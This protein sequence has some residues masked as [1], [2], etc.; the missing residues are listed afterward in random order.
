M[1]TAEGE[2]AVVGGIYRERCMR[3]HWN[4]VFGSAGRA[5]SALSTFGGNVCLHGFADGRTEEAIQAHAALEGFRLQLTTVEAVA[6]FHYIHGLARPGIKLPATALPTLRV[7]AHNVLQFGTLEPQ[8]IVE[9]D[10]AV[11]DPQNVDRPIGFRANGST[12]RELALVLNQGEART[13]VGD[14][15]L[16]AEALASKLAEQE[17]ADVVVIKRGP[18]GALVW[19]QGEIEI[20][21]A[22]RTTS[23]WKIG[24]GDHF[25]AHFAQAWLQEGISAIDAAQR[26]S[27]ATA[28]YCQHAGFPTRGALD[29]FT[30]TPIAPSKRY[31]DGW[32][33]CVYLAGPFFT[34][35]EL[36]LIEQ[37][38]SA[39]IGFGVDVFS[40]YHDVGHG[41][42]D[43]V[44]GQDL[45][46]I[47]KSD[48]LLA[49]AD[50]LD[51]GTIYEI[52]FARAL[53]KPVVVYAENEGEEDLK[54]MS[55]SH[56]VMSR[57]F[58][59]SIYLTVWESMST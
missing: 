16:D 50:G 13:L 18:L 58:V 29:A 5:A 57:D 51:S 10:R 32:R 20:V 9:C 36:W 52:G 14:A 17:L 6:R 8:A 55:G 11:Y 12:A 42:S 45:H 21:P 44:V 25:A 35:S 39:L 38:R 28:Y 53:G 40:P 3:P 56:C 54:M 15:S 47:E 46:G 22:Y 41:P 26:A 37:A 34:L 1:S 23:V 7:S 31:L 27:L 30:G 49:V 48:V 43:V 33:P 59:S 4:E 24:S 2:I 19:H